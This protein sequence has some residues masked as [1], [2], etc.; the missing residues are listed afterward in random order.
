MVEEEMEE[1][2]AWKLS[3]L[4]NDID[5][6]PNSLSVPLLVGLLWCHNLF[7]RY[8]IGQI[9]ITKHLV[10]NILT[11]VGL[12]PEQVGTVGRTF[13][14]ISMWLGLSLIHI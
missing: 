7:R 12:H 2:K 11:K 3:L 9:N 10:P 8:I 1:T 13:H 6:E 14:V 4:D 5:E